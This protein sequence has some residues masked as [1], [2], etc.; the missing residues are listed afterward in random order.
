MESSKRLR[1]K[2]GHEYGV[3]KG[4]CEGEGSVRAARE[5]PAKGWFE[6]MSMCRE[7]T[8]WAGTLDVVDSGWEAMDPWSRTSNLRTKYLLT[9][10]NRTYFGNFG[11]ARQCLLGNRILG[12]RDVIMTWCPVD[13]MVAQD[14][15]WCG[16]DG[17]CQQFHIQN[18][19]NWPAAKTQICASPIPSIIVSWPKAVWW[20]LHPGVYDVNNEQSLIM[21]DGSV[22]STTTYNWAGWD[23]AGGFT[24][25]IKWDLWP[26]EGAEDFGF[27]DF[28]GMLKCGF[29][30]ERPQ[31]R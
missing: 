6:F 27:V 20:T 19:M 26:D 30:E 10:I 1:E 2:V 3:I 23:A 8:S 11:S 9:F 12:V 15:K 29:G 28:E 17:T 5:R 18:K 22:A 13:V 31:G 24:L 16:E 25:G 21:C 14:R 7:K 4:E